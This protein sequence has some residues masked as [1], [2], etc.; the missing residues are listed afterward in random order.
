MALA[1]TPRGSPLAC[2]NRHVVLVGRP[3]KKASLVSR[4]IWHRRLGHVG[5]QHLD[6]LAKFVDGLNIDDGDN[7]L[8]PCDACPAGKSKGPPFPKESRNPTTAPNQFVHTDLN[9]IMSGDIRGH[10]YAH[11]MVDDYTREGMLN[12]LHFKSDAPKTLDKWIR[13]FD[14]PWAVRSVNA[15]ELTRGAWAKRC[16]ERKIEPLSTCL[17]TPQQNGIAERRLAVL[18]ADAKT[19]CALAELPYEDFW[20]YA[21]LVANR[22]RITKAKDVNVPPQMRRTGLKPDVSDVRVFVDAWLMCI[23]SRILVEKPTYEPNEE[24]LLDI[25]I[26]SV[27]GLSWTLSLAKK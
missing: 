14:C 17:Y 21:Q 12:L 8:E 9:G 19:M 25:R 1:E 4:R 7:T 11:V 2:L 15:R 16:E 23:R 22:V 20:G 6:Q 13:R 10:R 24:S 5:S 3:P 18:E 26:N 27:V